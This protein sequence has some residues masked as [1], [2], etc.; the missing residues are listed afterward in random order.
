MAIETTYN[1]SC[2][3]GQVTYQIETP[4]SIFQYCHCSRC[5]KVTG[6]GFA[7]NI[8]VPLS[9]FSW[10]TGEH[11]LKRYE[12]PDAKYFAS[13]FCGQCGSNLPWLTKTGQI[14][15]LP[16][17]TLDDEIEIKPSQNIFCDE[18]PNWHVGCNELKMR[19][20]GPNS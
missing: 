16:A 7:P 15:V 9:Q 14:Y 19:P 6:S 20:Q 11:L 18:R 13:C 1:G 2:L 4:L 3:C 10:L 12:I 17:G 8:F 5:R